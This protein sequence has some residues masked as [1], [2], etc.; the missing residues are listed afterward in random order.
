VSA[1][2]QIFDVDR[3]DCRIVPYDWPFD[4]DAGGE[5]D[6]HWRLETRRNPKLYDGVVLLASRVE[7][8]DD[9][10]NGRALRVDFFEA[11]FSRFLAW[12]DFN[13][14]DSNIFNCF[15]MPALRSCDGAFLLGE[16]AEGHSAAGRIYFPCGTPDREDV[17]GDEVDLAGSVLRELAEETGIRLKRGDLPR[18]WRIVRRG[19]KVACIKIVE[20]PETAQALEEI[21]GDHIRR[22][23]APELARAHMFDRRAQLADPR[24][25]PFMA[26]F[27]ERELRR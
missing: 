23:S 10:A 5:I 19:Q 3:L 16:M 8:Q 27:L 1:A 11:R 17:A 12:R 26:A 20:R 24:L 9:P 14:P 7:T 2:T 25:P 21:T 4:R 22:E 18:P 6:R 13:Y 15:A